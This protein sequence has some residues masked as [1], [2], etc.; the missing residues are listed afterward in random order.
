MEK[1]HSSEI[2]LTSQQDKRRCNYS[3]QHL[4]L[5]GR[6]HHKFNAITNRFMICTPQEIFFSDDEIKKNEMGGAYAM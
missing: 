1:V 6:R 2:L 4:R 5:S 3:E